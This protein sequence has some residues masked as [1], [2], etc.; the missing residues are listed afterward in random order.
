MPD[1]GDAASKHNRPHFDEGIMAAVALFHDSPPDNAVLTPTCS[2]KNRHS[3][4]TGKT[5]D[6]YMTYYS[7]V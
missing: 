3:L 6:I 2:T 5:C 1:M 4:Q 7:T